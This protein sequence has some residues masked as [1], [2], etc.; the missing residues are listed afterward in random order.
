MART[1]SSPSSRHRRFDFAVLEWKGPRVGKELSL[2]W[3]IPFAGMLLSIALFPL[4]APRFWHHHFRKVS[5]GWAALLAVPFLLLY[6]AEAWHEILHIFLLDYV[7]F[8]I[9]LWALFT[10]SGGILIK[11]S[12]AGTPWVNTAIILVGTAIASWIGTTGASMLLIRPLLRANEN[13]RHKTHTIVFFIFLVSNIGGSLTPLGDP[14]LFLGFLHGVP[15]FWTLTNLFPQ[16]LVATAIVTVAYFLF[17][18]VQYRRESPDSLVATTQPEPLGIAGKV[19]F[20]LLLG[21]IA[22]VLVSGYWNP[23]H[24]G[25]G[26]WLEH[27]DLVVIGDHANHAP[28]ENRA[29]S[30]HILPEKHLAEPEA[31]EGHH[32]I[33]IPIQNLAR[34]GILILMGLVSLTVTPAGVRAANGFSWF[35]IKEVAWLFAGIFMTIIPALQILAAGKEGAFEALVQTVTTPARYFWAT[36]ILSS[37][38]DNAPTYLTFFNTALGQFYPGVPESEALPRLIA[39]NGQY[40]VAIACGAVFMGANTYIGNAPNFMVRSIA[41]EAGVPMPDFFSFMF[42]YSIPFLGTTFV[43][44]TYLFFWG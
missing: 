7:P 35:P 3:V 29:D 30:G 19:N 17:D 28:T 37:F 21:V 26:P 1:G 9:L 32:G 23:D 44:I 39:E 16:F 38:L 34:D 18:V 5:M 43:I 8:V 11:G 31:L 40:L 10:V 13:R 15:F 42:K 41:E 2:L 4:F 22:G 33:R 14:P 6:R 12:M 36:G 25:S 27:G 24:L 20:L